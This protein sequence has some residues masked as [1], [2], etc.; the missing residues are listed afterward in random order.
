MQG[1]AQFVLRRTSDFL[2]IL[3]RQDDDRTVGIGKIANG[4]G[5]LMFEIL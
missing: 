2:K 4:E 1:Q 5:L 3:R